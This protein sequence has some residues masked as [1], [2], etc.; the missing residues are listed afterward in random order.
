MDKNQLANAILSNPFS[1]PI[2]KATAQAQLA[3]PV[4]ETPAPATVMLSGSYYVYNYV[5]KKHDE[6]VQ[7]HKPI[8]VSRAFDQELRVLCGEHYYSQTV[9]N[10]ACQAWSY[11]GLAAQRLDGLLA[12][13]LR[14][15]Y[16][17]EEARDAEIARLKAELQFRFP[18]MP[19]TLESVA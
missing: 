7:V 6:L 5:S 13:G 10:A 12:G 2:E 17:T 19:H 8:E 18:T 1:T 16:P 15:I 3:T 14:N 11:Y 4:P 9:L